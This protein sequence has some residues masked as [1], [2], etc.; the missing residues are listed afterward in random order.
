MRTDHASSLR[1][2]GRKVED[3]APGTRA[4]LPASS[5]FNYVRASINAPVTMSMPPT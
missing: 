5:F 2:H 4:I 1:C 3:V